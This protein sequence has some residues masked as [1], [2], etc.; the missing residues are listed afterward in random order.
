MQVGLHLR[1]ILEAATP[2]IIL[3][4]IL[5]SEVVADHDHS[6]LSVVAQVTNPERAGEV[7]VGPKDVQLTGESGVREQS[8]S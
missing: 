7:F 1:D 4:K 5:V 3:L 2:L 8:H 6:S